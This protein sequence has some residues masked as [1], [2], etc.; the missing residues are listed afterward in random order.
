VVHKTKREGKKR[1]EKK[2]EKTACI[3]SSQKEFVFSAAWRIPAPDKESVLLTV[4]KV[5]GRPL[6]LFLGPGP[7]QAV[8]IESCVPPGEN[9]FR[10][11]GTEKF[12]A[13]KIGQEALE[14][15]G[16]HPVK[17]GP[18]RMSRTIDSRHGE[19]KASRNGP[20]SP[21]KQDLPEKKRKPGS[22]GRFWARERQPALTLGLEY[23]T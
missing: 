5:Y 23:E 7:D 19:R 8:D 1:K 18:L 16:K 11:H 22:N 6:G 14:V 21:R 2:K 9:A 12:P 15:T 20:T 3:T 13:D 4:L 10:P 17:D